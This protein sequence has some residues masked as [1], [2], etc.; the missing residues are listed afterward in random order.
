MRRRRLTFALL[1]VLLLV[2]AVASRAAAQRGDLLVVA[3]D[4]PVVVAGQPLTVIPKNF[5]WNGVARL[6]I[7][8]VA[9]GSEPVTVV[10][11]L[12]LG[13]R[14]RAAL[15]AD[16]TA[17][18]IWRAELTGTWLFH[19][20]LV[21]T[22]PILL[23]ATP[24]STAGTLALDSPVAAALALVDGTALG[25]WFFELPDATAVTLQAR[26]SGGS[27]PLTL[28]L[29]TT[30][31][32]TL[33]QASALI[34]NEMLPA[35]RYL[36]AVR[37]DEATDY[38][39][40]LTS[41]LSGDTEG[42]SLSPGTLSLGLLSPGED[43]DEYTFAADPGDVIY[44]AM[45]ATD[46]TLDPYLEIIDPV[47]NVVAANDDASGF[48][49]ALA[50]IAPITGQYTLR[51][52]SNQGNTS[53][54]YTLEFA[55]DPEMTRAAPATALALGRS[56]QGE[57]PRGGAQAWRLLGAAGD[58]LGVRVES[59]G[60]DFDPQLT[61]YGPDGG[62]LAFSDDDG[63]GLSPMINT[64]LPDDGYYTLVVGSYTGAAGGY[65]IATASEP[66]PTPAP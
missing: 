33:R 55:H 64:T 24:G 62:Q 59:H 14:R 51:L 44:A 49:A 7:S 50:Y 20:P 17:P 4:P 11:A 53:G 10:E 28:T 6:N 3:F 21:T 47:G 65:T 34:A 66:F 39:M 32:N 13:P 2:F 16:V 45:T 38:T 5:N 26:P 36:V 58:S 41:G 9:E 27:G 35:G 31:G 15:P 40:S 48:D 37:G 30:D 54:G 18:G 46:A 43:V 42:G 60:D 63:G 23:A 12:K 57:V 1:P 29:L 25:A 56:A 8:L 22:S 19:T 52:S 61:L